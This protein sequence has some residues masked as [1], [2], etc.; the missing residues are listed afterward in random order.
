MNISKELNKVEQILSIREYDADNMGGFKILTTEQE[1]VLGIDNFQSWCESWGY[2]VTEVEDN[3]NKYKG[4]TLLDLK[5]TDT[6]LKSFNQEE[7]T[8]DFNNKDFDEDGKIRLY[9]GEAIFVDIITNVGV[10]QFCAYNEHNGYYGHEVVIESKKL[11][12]KT[13]L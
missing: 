13:C 7:L 9:E 11:T 10:L 6:Q 5:I 8:G 1:I 2:F 4:A 3:F 12:Y